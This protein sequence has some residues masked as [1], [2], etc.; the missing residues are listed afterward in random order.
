MPVMR[1]LL[2]A[3]I[4]FFIGPFAKANGPMEVSLH[5]VCPPATVSNIE[6]SSDGVF[7]LV[8]GC[9]D[10]AACNYDATA[11]DE[12]GSCE[13]CSCAELSQVSAASF[14]ALDWL[15]F[16][17][18]V[19]VVANHDTTQGADL[20]EG[21]TF[22]LY[23]RAD[24]DVL[25]NPLIVSAVYGNS[26]NPWILNAPS[27][28]YQHPLGGA[29]PQNASPLIWNLP[30]FEGL[31]FDSWFT[32]GVDRN[33]ALL[34][35]GYD[36]PAAIGTWIDFFE[37][38][39]PGTLGNG[40]SITDPVGSICYVLPTALNCLPDDNGR[41]LIAQLTSDGT[42]SGTIS[43]QYQIDLGGFLE[44]FRVSFDF[45]TEG[46]GEYTWDIPDGCDCTEDFDEDG[47]CDGVDICTDTA[48]C[49]YAD[50]QNPA[51]LYLDECGVCGGDGIAEGACDCEG[52]ILDE[53]G[54][55]GGSC[56]AD[57]DQDGLCDDQDTCIGI[58]DECGVC[59]GPGP[60][61]ECG[62][63]PRPPGD[64][65]CNGNQLDALGTCGGD[66]T[67]DADGDG[68]CDNVD[69][70]VGSLDSCGVCNGPGSIYSCGCA[71]I[72]AGDCDCEGN[73]LDAL[74]ICGGTCTADVDGD[75]VCD[76]DE[77]PG[78]TNPFACNYDSTATDDDGFCEVFDA[79]GECGG[80]CT[81]DGDGDGV[82]DDVDEC[83]GTLDACGVCNGPGEIYACGCAGIPAGD[84]DCDGNLLDALGVCGGSCTSD[85]DGDGICDDVDECVGTLDACGACNGPGEIYACGCAG[86]QAG[87]CDCDG[88]ELDALGV[89]GGTCAADSDGDG[90]CDD[91]EV[92]GCMTPFACN[93]DAS[94]TDDDGTCES[95]RRHWR[96]WRH[97]HF[98]CGRRRH[99]RR[100]RRLRGHPGCLRDLQRPGE[101]YACGCAG[102]PAGDCDC[103]GNQ[104]DAL[105]VCGGSC[106]SDADGDGICDDVDECVG[107]LDACG[108]CNG[109]GE[110]YA[111]G[112]AGI[113]PVIAT[114]TA[115]SS[116]PWASAAALARRIRTATAYATMPRC[117]VA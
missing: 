19:E 53:A 74:E 64:C 78:C 7:L 103:D 115:T 1:K 80:I 23:A 87:D 56:N 109:P 88:N 117:Q 39:P 17:L 54:I 37:P 94:A 95:N 51:C 18:D 92:P 101:I 63:A 110:I 31:E 60:F 55:C 34:G 61:L 11:T 43:V 106:T 41:I 81:S 26:Q 57:L 48:A 47:L 29:T 67:A 85:A 73:A 27:G 68:I 104:L 98:G 79:V 107:T 75:G 33:A 114:A 116:M 100:C 45:T 93:Y 24:T 20:P 32:I 38:S 102:I 97:V 66:C 86:I 111:C 108:A 84:C 21:K 76:I 90:I 89:C 112:C 14:S 13:Y 25:G 22:R 62:C 5:G 44:D 99:L 6:W 49:N 42:I 16:N 72:P 96:L 58:L 69:D 12:D 91:A 28:F 59:N 36:D 3:L 50:I 30:G 4:C 2:I 52:N 70:C 71:D 65:D 15:G 8:S 82:C 83:V 77:T 40:F 46:L 105:G 35:P 10:P 113:Q 9:T